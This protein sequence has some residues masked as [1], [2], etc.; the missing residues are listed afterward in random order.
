VALTLLD[1]TDT[2]PTLAPQ[3]L[4]VVENPSVLEAALAAGSAAPFACTSGQLRAVDHVL[5]ALAV[6]CGVRLRYAGD[7]DAS[8]LAVAQAVADGYGAELVAMD[9]AT[10][11]AATPAPSRVPLT[12]LPTGVGPALTDALTAHGRVV[13]QEHDAVL[14]RILRGEP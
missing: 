4:T 6:A 14:D 8:G 10:V 11:A 9:A 7:L 2:P 1:L 12:V 3:T 13:F 5:L